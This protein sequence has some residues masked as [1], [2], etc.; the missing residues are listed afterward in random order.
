MPDH[1]SSSPATHTFVFADLAGY[2]ALTEA[3]GDERAADAAAAFCAM[4]RTLLDEHDTEEVKAIGD[5]LMLRSSDAPKAAG[6]AE[7]IVCGYGARH[8]ELGVRIGMHT[9]TAV[10]RGNDWFGSAVNIASRVAD[11]ARAGEVLC[12]GATREA[13]GPAAAVR[14]RGER[15]F[16]N[17]VT[18]IALYELV[19]SRSGEA[20]P[21]DPVCRMAIEPAQAVSR[22]LH[23]AVEY[24]FCSDRCAEAFERAP[25]M[26]ANTAVQRP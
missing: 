13:L 24:L 16:K 17:V 14:D 20:L 23:G 4:V 3:H 7:R 19:L 15:S 21:V 1:G 6:L 25:A 5:A 12:T 18:P 10:R 9:G 26:Y 11:V 22:C 8:L 2:T